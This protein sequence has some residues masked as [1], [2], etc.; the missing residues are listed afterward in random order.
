[1]TFQIDESLKRQ[2]DKPDAAY[3]LDTFLRH[4]RKNVRSVPRLEFARLSHEAWV[5]F[6]DASLQVIRTT[7]LFSKKRRA[8]VHSVDGLP[9]EMLETRQGIHEFMQHHAP[10]NRLVLLK[11]RL[12]EEKSLYCHLPD[13]RTQ[14]LCMLQKLCNED[15]AVMYGFFLGK[16]EPRMST[17]LMRTRLEQLISVTPSMSQ[18][19]DLLEYLNAMK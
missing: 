12:L 6:C 7:L 15:A 9:R 17:S 10:D 8:L 11:N 18:L 16:W 13:R 14:A 5:L 4:Y 3:A 2:W 19:Q 1:M